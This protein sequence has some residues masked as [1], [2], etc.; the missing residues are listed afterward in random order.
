MIDDKIEN[1]DDIFTDEW[2][3]NVIKATDFA[4]EH[5]KSNVNE[6]ALIKYIIDYNIVKQLQE[7]VL[8][9]LVNTLPK[10][11]DWR[12]K[13]IVN[14]FNEF[15]DLVDSCNICSKFKKYSVKLILDENTCAANELFIWKDLV[16]SSYPN[17]K[18]ILNKLKL[19][20]QYKL[21]IIKLK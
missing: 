10:Q 5:N 8:D 14:I 16:N 1:L 9:N 15:K 6:E 12:N 7:K 20:N 17:L 11:I 4:L 3:N 2:Y 21:Q 13:D 18:L 19:K